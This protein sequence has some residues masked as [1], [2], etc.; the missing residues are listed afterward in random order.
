MSPMFLQPVDIVERN[1]LPQLIDSVMADSGFDVQD[2]F[3]PINV[4]VNIPP[5]FRKN[6]RRNGDQR[7]KYF[8]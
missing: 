3:V 1:K 7:S 5:L 2:M 4:T 8:K 6:I